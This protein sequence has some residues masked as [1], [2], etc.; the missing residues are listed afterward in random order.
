MVNAVPIA[1]PFKNSRLDLWFRDEELATR[2]RGLILGEIELCSQCSRGL[3]FEGDLQGNPS[4]RPCAFC[5]GTGFVEK[6]D[7]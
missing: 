2:V 1:K 4:P 5:S 6:L 3:V 7:E